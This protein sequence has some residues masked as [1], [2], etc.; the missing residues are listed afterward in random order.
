MYIEGSGKRS[1]LDMAALCNTEIVVLHCEVYTVNYMWKS[2]K[3]GVKKEG[4]EV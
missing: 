3:V 4:L 1:P 2:K